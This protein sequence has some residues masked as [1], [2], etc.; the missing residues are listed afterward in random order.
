MSTFPSPISGFNGTSTYAADLSNAIQ[1]AVS[2]ASLP[3]QQLSNNVNTFTSEQSALNDL[4]SSFNSLQTALASIGTAAASGNYSISYS[5]NGVVSATASSGAPLG[6]YSL[7]VV[8][9]GSQASAASTATVRDPGTQSIS[10]S[11]VFTLTANGQTYI[12]IVPPPGANTLTTLVTAIN[13]A[14]QG[15]VQATIVNVGTAASP[16]YQLSIQNTSYGDLPITLTDS[17]G[18]N[19]LGNPTAATPVQYYVNGQPP[20]SQGPLTSNSRTLSIGPNISATVLGAGTT[21]FT[22][23][24]TTANI[25]NA[26]SHFVTAYNSASQ[27]LAAQ[28]GTN[29]GALEGQSIVRTLSQALHNISGYTGSGT[30]QSMAAIGLTFDQNGV[31]SFDPSVLSSAASTDFQGVLNFLGGP[32]TGGFLEAATNTLNSITDA[33]SGVIATGLNTLTSEITSTNAQI[34]KEQDRVNTLQQNLNAQMSAADALIASM[35]SQLSYMTSLLSV[36]NANNNA[37]IA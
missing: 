18:N 32:T 2:I 17:D 5:S 37:S 23:G 31:L 24:Q 21:R 27:T 11:S 28:H 33:T 8:D 19:L 6:T 13:T 12:N 26:I 3:I 29:G 9:P 10:N 25:A 34:A 4:N 20:A 35:Q 7:Q 1:R 36:T 15:A 30:I 14:T 16:Q 22:V